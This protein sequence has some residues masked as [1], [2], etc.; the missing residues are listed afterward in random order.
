VYS[1]CELVGMGLAYNDGSPRNR[2]RLPSVIVSLSPA[3]ARRMGGNPHAN[4]GVPLR[5]L[6]LPDF[7]QYAVEV[8]T[9]GTTL[10][11]PTRRSS[12]STPA[13]AGWRATC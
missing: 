3:G 11:E 5:E 1:A 10:A 13:R 12:P 9:A 7:R 2:A 4:G 8:K 6:D